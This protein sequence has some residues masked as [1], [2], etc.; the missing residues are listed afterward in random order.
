[1]AHRRIEVTVVAGIGQNPK[2][3]CWF[4]WFRDELAIFALFE[5]SRPKGDF[6]SYANIARGFEGRESTGPTSVG[7]RVTPDIATRLD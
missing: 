4:L 7:G 6:P 2:R 5:K 3:S 1:M